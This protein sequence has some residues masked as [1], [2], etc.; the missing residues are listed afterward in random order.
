MKRGME[1]L[2]RL[3]GHGKSSELI[4][5]LWRILER[6]YLIVYG[7]WPWKAG[8]PW[9]SVVEYPVSLPGRFS[10]ERP[11]IPC[12]AMEKIVGSFGALERFWNVV[13]NSIPLVAVEGWIAKESLVFFVVARKFP[14]VPG[15][16]DG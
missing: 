6:R 16:F 14:G 13:P 12:R 2:D 9:K 8:S 3:V 1:G 15:F 11:A 5:A 4:L 10:M 7:L